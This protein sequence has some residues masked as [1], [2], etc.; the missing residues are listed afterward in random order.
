MSR[1]T[2]LA[3]WILFILLMVVFSGRFNPNG[4]INLINPFIKPNLKQIVEQSLKNTE[5]KFGIYIKNLKTLEQYNLND[6]LQFEAGSLY[7]LW[8][9]GAV[10]KKI[11]TEELSEDQI[12]VGDIARLNRTF[13]IAD[14]GAELTRGTIEYTIKE[15]LEQMITIS[16]NYA[17]F[18]LTLE[19]GNEALEDFLKEYEL[20]ESSLG[21]PKTTASDI[22]K[23]FEKLYLGQIVDVDSSAKMLDILSRQTINDRIPKLLPEGTK[24]AHKTG[25]IGFVESDGGIV[26]TPSGDYIVVVLS[27]TDSPPTATETIANL[28]KAVY[29]YFTK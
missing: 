20:N 9:M 23:F 1:L 4:P 25:D 12:I 2:K 28:S 11:P 10:Y 29:D 15:A 3:I 14:E 22:G 8:V 7:K 26:F 24:V 21:P 6:H 17:A 19:V 5:G 18:M 13:G 16:H 27:Q